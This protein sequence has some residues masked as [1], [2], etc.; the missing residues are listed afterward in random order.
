M[1]EIP[2]PK[3]S[4]IPFLE[5][6]L[7]LEK[8]FPQP[9]GLGSTVSP[10]RET[11]RFRANPSLSFPAEEIA[12]IGLPP[13][14]G[15]PVTVTAN[16]FGLHGPSSPL[17]PALTERVILAEDSGALR[18]FLDLFNHRLLSLLFLIWKHYRHGH[19]YQPG[20]TDAISRAVAALFGMET[21]NRRT[22]RPLLLPYA[23]LLALSSRSASVM[24]S[25]VGD[26]LGVPCAWTS[27]SSG[28]S[29]SPQ[30]RSGPSARQPP[31][32][33]ETASRAKRWATSPVDSGCAWAPSMP[34][35]RSTVARRQRLSI[36]VEIINLTLRDPI[37]WDLA[38][39]LHPG[40]ARPLIL[41]KLASAGR[42]GSRFPPKHWWN[43]AF[44][45]ENRHGDVV[46]RRAISQ[47]ARKGE[48]R[49]P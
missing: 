10:S 37:E 7:W 2:L 36:L 23:G 15:G 13:E 43:S 28:R 45:F 39:V 38:F 46:R 32:S 41:G 27:S 5:L 33:A 3:A 20:A 1:S 29:A 4:D 25:I 9:G 12:A 40:E 34:P 30:T 8:V 16:M 48:P 42:D 18:D 21:D 49:T 44:S 14:P 35:V 24:S 22:A 47:T 19:R 31:P 26:R 17:P 11:V 6:C